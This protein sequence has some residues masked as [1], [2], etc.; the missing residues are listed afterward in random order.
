MS[1]IALREKI[2]T[3]MKKVLSMLVVLC[4]VASSS[5]FAA[6]DDR[7]LFVN[8]T[9]DEINRATMAIVF[10][11]RVLT[12]QNIP[13]TISLSVEGARIAD[14]NIPETINSNGD[15]LKG[16]LKEFM[17]KGGRVLICEMCMTNVAGLKENEVLE[18]VEVGGGMAAMLDSGTTVISF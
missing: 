7:K 1:I 15:S 10:G 16:L 12:E 14:I 3:T 17:E 2:M 11:T 9:S 13:V 6:D 8:L 5:V 4:L 18:G